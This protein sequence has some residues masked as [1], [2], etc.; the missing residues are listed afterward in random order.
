MNTQEFKDILAYT[1]EALTRLETVADKVLK[2]ARLFGVSIDTPNDPP[3]SSSGI[4]TED[5]ANSA[6][7]SF[8]D[9]LTGGQEFSSTTLKERVP[10]LRPFG[11]KF[12]ANRMRKSYRAVDTGTRDTHG[13]SIFR[14]EERLA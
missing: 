6:I 7:L 2:L 4:W 12:L 10:G 9:N 1:P 3:Q 8:T 14:I 13:R 11:H 5:Q